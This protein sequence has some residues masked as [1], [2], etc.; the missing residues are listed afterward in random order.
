MYDTDQCHTHL[1]S[2]CVFFVWGGVCVCVCVVGG[3]SFRTV[4]CVGCFGGGLC[5]DC[6]YRISYLA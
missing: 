5:S 2:L 1:N 6:V 3:G 4:L